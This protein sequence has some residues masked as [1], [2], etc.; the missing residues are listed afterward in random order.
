ME[1]TEW[2]DGWM[3]WVGENKELRPGARDS[4]AAAK[5]VHQQGRKVATEGP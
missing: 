2:M 5:P 3:E 1:R 4:V